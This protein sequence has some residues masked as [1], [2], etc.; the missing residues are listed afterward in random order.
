MKTIIPVILLLAFVACKKPQPAPAPQPAP[1]TPSQPAS[2]AYSVTLS[3]TDNGQG[4]SYAEERHEYICMCLT[5]NLYRGSYRRGTYF[6]IVAAKNY[7]VHVSVNVPLDSSKLQLVQLNHKY[8]INLY[9]AIGTKDSFG[10]FRFNKVTGTGTD[11][12]ENETDS[13]TYFNK[14]TSITY[15]GNRRY[16]QYEKAMVC[17]YEIA[18]EFNIRVKNDLSNLV[19]VVSNG[20][21]KLRL[22]FLAQ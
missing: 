9:T 6:Q 12:I 8:P 14:F 5:A 15:L 17:E 3:Y 20:K 10:T 11:L 4:E 7:N 2:S 1:S 13:T 18:G 21:Y 19:R 16:D 22:S